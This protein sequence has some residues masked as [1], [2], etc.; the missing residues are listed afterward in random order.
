MIL[1]IGLAL[2][3]TWMLWSFLPA[4]EWASVLAIATWPLYSIGQ[5]HLGQTW[6]AATPVTA[7][8]LVILVPMLLIAMEM[9]REGGTVVQ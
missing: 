6:T 4:I 1:A 7:I 3:A 5:R 8:T 2:L 9:A